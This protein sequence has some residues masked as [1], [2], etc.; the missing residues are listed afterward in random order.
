METFFTHLIL[1]QLNHKSFLGGFKSATLA[2][3]LS[4]ETYNFT[5]YVNKTRRFHRVKHCL[6]IPL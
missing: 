6:H 1:R 5:T 4:P 2:S 3:N